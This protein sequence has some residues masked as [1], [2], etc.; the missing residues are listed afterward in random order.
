MQ[1]SCARQGVNVGMAGSFTSAAALR[2]FE[3][4]D[5]FALKAM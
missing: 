2:P 3:K 4:G 1:F 5:L